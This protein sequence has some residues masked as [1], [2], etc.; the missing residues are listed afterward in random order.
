MATEDISGQLSVEAEKG[1]ADPPAAHTL[2][3]NSLANVL[4]GVSTTILAVVLPPVLARTLSTAEFSVW[5]LILQVAGYTAL[6]NLGMQGAVGRYVAFHLA[7][8]ERHQGG[9]F[10]VTAFAILCAA[11]ALALAGMIAISQA[12]PAVFPAIPPSLLG[13]ASFCLLVVGATLALGLPISAF[14]GVFAAIQRNEL[15]TLIVGTSRILQALALAAAAILTHSVKILAV[16]FSAINLASFLATWAC[17]RLLSPVPFGISLLS[18]AALAEIGRFCGSVMIWNVSMFL[19]SGADTAIVGRFDF[20][21]VGVYAACLAPITVL[22]GVQQ[23]LFGPLLQ[24]GAIQ[25]ARGD[26][27][28]LNETLTRATRI[29]VLV[30][31]A[32]VA[33]LL[34][35]RNEILGLWLGDAYARQAMLV[36][37]LLLIGHFTRLIAMPYATLLVATGEHRRVIAAPVTEGLV[38]VSVALI[39][40]AKFGATGVAIGAVVGAVTAQLL[41]YFYNLPRTQGRSFER[42]KLLLRVVVVPL[43]CF[44]PAALGLGAGSLGWPLSLSLALR[45][46]LLLASVILAWTYALDAREREFA[47]KLLRRVSVS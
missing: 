46:L 3:K 8:D 19:V 33:I 40:G 37:P 38:N 36:F 14:N 13:S 35:F 47:S 17:F 28:G 6:L 30:L 25:S 29:G 20:Q 43:A 26:R 41:N 21:R 18:R 27:A 10:L 9:E 4:T 12:L 11:A 24:V 31:L 5:S 15:I 23:A 39:A 44:L 45:S 2:V 42:G 34:L 22:A 7:R 16:T 32:P 1:S